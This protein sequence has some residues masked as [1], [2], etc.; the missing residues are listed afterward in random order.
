MAAKGAKT[1]GCE[2]PVSAYARECVC[3]DV[4]MQ[5]GY[6]GGGGRGGGAYGGPYGAPYGGRGGGY[7][8]YGGPGGGPDLRLPPGW[9]DCPEFGQPI[10]VDAKTQ[11]RVIPSK[12]SDTHT[13]T[14]THKPLPPHKG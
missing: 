8:G 5:G 11:F 14:H 12:V 3:V 2:T 10:Q 7:N 13:Y 4:S 9:E 1:A 6:Q